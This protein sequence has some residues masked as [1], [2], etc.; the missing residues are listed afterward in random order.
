MGIPIVTLP[1]SLQRS[2]HT[3]G[4]YR[5]IN[6]MDLVAGSKSDYAA[7]AVAVAND[8]AFRAHCQARIA[9][10]AGVLYENTAFVRHCEE[11]F[12]NMV[13]QAASASRNAIR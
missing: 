13:E 8:P 9:E 10:S 7:K 3:R 11:A 5:A 6:F 4:M 2:R 1:G 12:V